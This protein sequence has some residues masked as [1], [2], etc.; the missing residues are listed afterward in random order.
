MKKL[1]GI[2]GAVLVAAVINLNAAVVG[3]DVPTN[4]IHQLTVAVYPG[5]SPNLTLA[6]GSESP[7][8]AGVALLYPISPLSPYVLV[9]GRFDWLAD[10]FWAPSVDLTIQV[11]VKVFGVSVTPFALGGAI[12]PI[13][14]SQDNHEVGAIVGAGAYATVWRPSEATS[15]QLFYAYEHWFNLECDVHRPGLAFTVKF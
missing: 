4:A 1:I 10:E 15:L 11:P 8:G 2:I 9:G 7:W 5:F 13:G 14:G 3:L 6:D 12:Y